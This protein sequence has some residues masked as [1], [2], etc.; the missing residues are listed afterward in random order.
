MKKFVLYILIFIAAVAVI[1]VAFNFACQYLNGHAKGGD[2][3]SNYDITNTVTSPVVIFGS[4]RAIHHYEPSELEK[5]LGKEVYNC[6][7]D[8]NGILF[9]YGRFRLMTGRYTPEAIIYDI[10]P[11]FDIFVDDRSK[12]LGLLKRWYG[13][14]ELD[15]LIA[16]IDPK[17]TVKL[18]SALYR[19][20][21]T[22]VQMLS[23]NF[24][25]KQNVAYH[26]FKPLDGVIDYDAKSVAV[27]SK[28]WDPLKKKYFLKLIEECR[29]KKIRLIIGLSPYY[30]EIDKK[31]YEPIL[32]LCREHDIPVID[33]LTDT[34]ITAHRGYFQDA[35]HLNETGARAFT[36]KFAP[37]LRELLTDK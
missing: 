17:E 16:D 30:G 23:D 14:P 19:F 34:T 4:S 2:T 22:F 29:Q 36:V 5:T 3:A 26:G 32:Q 8:G 33:F 37:R 9:F 31:K 11:D 18:K 24:S 20:N 25:P 28:E 35:T 1:D 7:A 12:Y 10:E 21:G 13:R 27:K 15:S 6:G